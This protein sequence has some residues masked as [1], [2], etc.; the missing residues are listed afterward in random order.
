[1]EKGVHPYGMQTFQMSVADLLA[2]QGFIDEDGG[3]GGGRNLTVSADLTGLGRSW[4]RLRLDDARRAPH[5][6]RDDERDARPPP[7]PNSRS[8]TQRGVVGLERL[9]VHRHVASRRRRRALQLVMT[10]SRADGE[11]RTERQRIRYGADAR[12]RPCA[13]APCR[14]PPP[15]AAVRVPTLP[16]NHCSSDLRSARAASNVACASPT[17]FLAAR[18]ASSSSATTPKLD[19]SACRAS[20]S[21]SQRETRTDGAPVRARERR[22]PGR[23]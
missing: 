16:L 23:G 13:A 4:R 1:M 12:S 22:R 5:D 17:C 9:F 8:E 11:L 14:A 18:I 3:R 19:R 20:R 7:S 6:G 15:S 21:L 2:E 10:R